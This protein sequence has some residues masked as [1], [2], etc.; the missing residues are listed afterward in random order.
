[1][2][3]KVPRCEED[4]ME[5]GK[6]FVLRSKINSVKVKEKKNDEIKKTEKQQ[7]FY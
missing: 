4:E 7:K 2:L 3:R 6:L 1:M 5:K